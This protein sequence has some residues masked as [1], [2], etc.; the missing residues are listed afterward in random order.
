MSS[1]LQSPVLS[2][3]GL[4]FWVDQWVCDRSERGFKGELGS[5]GRN[6]LGIFWRWARTVQKLGIQIFRG[7]YHGKSI[8]IRHSGITGNRPAYRTIWQ[9]KKLW[10]SFGPGK[11]ESPNS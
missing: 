7:Q 2:E 4:Q 6:H 10:V 3:T 8:N 1:N 5:D 11:Y 9:T